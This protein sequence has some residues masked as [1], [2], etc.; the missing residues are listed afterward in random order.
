MFVRTKKSVGVD[1]VSSRSQAV[2]SLQKPYPTLL[3]LRQILILMGHASTI[4]LLRF[5]PFITFTKINL[6]NHYLYMQ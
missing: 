4:L 3:T 2:D 1:V 5:P 6:T